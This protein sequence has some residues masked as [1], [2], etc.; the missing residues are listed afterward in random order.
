MTLRWGRVF[1][2]R[3]RIRSGIQFTT[4]FIEFLAVE[5]KRFV[6]SFVHVKICSQR[7]SRA[8]ESKRRALGH[9]FSERICYIC[10]GD[11]D[12][13]LCTTS[14]LRKENLCAMATSVKK[15]VSIAG[16]ISIWHCA[17][18]L[19]SQVPKLCTDLHLNL[20]YILILGTYSN[21]NSLGKIIS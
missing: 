18:V 2:E 12:P 10:R 11:W 13:G 7:S 20:L 4:H 21:L 14:Y 3:M 6:G 9:Y 5:T 16:K 19:F 1:L 15:S 8:E 17:A